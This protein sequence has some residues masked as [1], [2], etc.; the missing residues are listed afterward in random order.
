VLNGW[1][2]APESGRYRFYLSCNDD[3]RLS[4]DSTNTYN[5]SDPNSQDSLQQ[6]LSCSG[7]GWRNY[8]LDKYNGQT[9]TRISDWI[10]LA[11][12]EYYKI[13]AV[14]IYSR[15]WTDYHMTVAVEFEKSNTVGMHHSNREVQILSIGQD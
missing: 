8:L 14:E 13:K 3:C 7:T 9:S 6:L 11:Q 1:F 4:L 15:H 12:G 2:K 10:T 5:P